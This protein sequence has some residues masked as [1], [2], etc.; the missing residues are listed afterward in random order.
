MTPHTSLYA[1]VE[2]DLANARRSRDE[3]GLRALGL[4]KSELV[5]ASKERGRS[6]EIDDELVLRILRREVKKRDEAAQAFRTGAREARAQAEE[7]EAEVLRS[8][9]PEPLGDAELE[10]EIRR[11]VAELGPSGPGALGSVMKTATARLGGRAEG[12]RIAAVARR[13]LGS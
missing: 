3:A 10:A 1:R 13:V 8:Y 4:L 6:G 2:V 5:N 11:V 12:G 7:A 9:L